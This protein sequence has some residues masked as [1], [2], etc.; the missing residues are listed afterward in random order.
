M[1]P[2]PLVA[3][4]I[5]VGAS[6]LSEFKK[7]TPIQAAFWLTESEESYPQPHVILDQLTEQNY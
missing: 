6:F 5:D 7:F 1:G 4:Q 2:V 3:E